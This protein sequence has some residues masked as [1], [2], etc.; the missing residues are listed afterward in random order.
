[1]WSSRNSER[2]I[3]FLFAAVIVLFP[4]QY[5]F[6]KCVTEP[7]PALLLPSFE[8]GLLDAAGE[9]S[10]ETAD[11]S[12]TFLGGT[13]QVI[14]LRSLFADAPSSQFQEMARCALHP[15][16]GG[17]PPTDL[18]S[19]AHWKRFVPWGLFPGFTQAKI[20]RQYWSGVEPPTVEW[21][22]GRMKDLF[23]GRTVERIEVVWYTATCSERN[24]WKIAQ[25]TPGPR[26]EIKL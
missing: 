18:W 7:Y 17:I 19:D 6:A 26:L 8:G 25:R 2:W 23:P 3:K 5:W 21:L 10:T 11:V 20:R 9:V 24:Q 14:S 22:R 4:L 16:P 13:T 15:K 12:V 1:M